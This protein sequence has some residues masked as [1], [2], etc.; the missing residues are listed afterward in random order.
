M[1]LPQDFNDAI[2]VTIYKK[3]GERSECGNHR[4]ISLLSVAGKMLA[5]IV[6]NRIRSISEDVLPESQYGFRAGRLTTD[7]I[8]TLRQLQEK[9][10]E[11]CQ[12]LYVVV[13]DFSKAFD[14]VDT[15]TLWKVLEFYVALGD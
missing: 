14:T 12:P 11:Q 7:M 1:A 8:F 15:Q 5:K 9:A 10:S 2:I 6:L 4:G 3:K 13:V